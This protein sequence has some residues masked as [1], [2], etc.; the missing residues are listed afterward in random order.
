MEMAMKSFDG[1]IVKARFDVD[2]F[3]IETTELIL[4]RNCVHYHDYANLGMVCDYDCCPRPED[5]YCD[6]AEKDE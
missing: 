6:R 5:G 1:V 4:C 2:F 3:G